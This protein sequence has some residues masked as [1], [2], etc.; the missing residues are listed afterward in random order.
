MRWL[1]VGRCKREGLRQRSRSKRNALSWGMREQL[2]SNRLVEA[3][4]KKPEY[5]GDQQVSKPQPNRGQHEYVQNTESTCTRSV[6][7]RNGK[8]KG[9]SSRFCER[10]WSSTVEKKQCAN[11]YDGVG[12][13]GSGARCCCLRRN[14]ELTRFVSSLWGKSCRPGP[15]ANQ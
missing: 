9:D 5:F 10:F 1:R 8:M 14:L 11:G 2:F 3:S 4:T 7:V 15:P 12:E 13:Y 6:A